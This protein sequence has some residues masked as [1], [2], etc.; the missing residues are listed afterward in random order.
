MAL[1]TPPLQ[2]KPSSLTGL[3]D[4]GVTFEV[5]SWFSSLF[6]LLGPTAR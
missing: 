2:R 6:K 3:L 4:G 1:K 5:A